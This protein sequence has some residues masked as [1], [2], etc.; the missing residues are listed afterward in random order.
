MPIFM[1]RQ[2]NKNEIIDD[3]IQNQIKERC[4]FTGYMYVFGKDGESLQFKGKKAEVT[5]IKIITIL[6]LNCKEKDT[7]YLLPSHTTKNLPLHLYEFIWTKLFNQSLAPLIIPA[8]S[9]WT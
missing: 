7:L 2:T 3:C 1:Y 9:T 5:L 6:R 4:F 8:F